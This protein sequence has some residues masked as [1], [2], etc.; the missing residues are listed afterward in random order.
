MSSSEADSGQTETDFKNMREVFS[1]H[2]L[3]NKNLSSVFSME[4]RAGRVEDIF[5]AYF[6]RFSIFRY[7]PDLAGAVTTSWG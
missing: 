6:S 3:K 1:Q 7:S 4:L 5:E 2:R